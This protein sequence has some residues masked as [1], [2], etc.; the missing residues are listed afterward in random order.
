VDKIAK[1]LS[2]LKYVDGTPRYTTWQDKHNLPPASPNWW[3]AI[4]DAIEHCDMFV[5]NLSRASL[6]SGVCRAELDYAHKRNRPIVPVVLEDEF[7]LDAQS[8]KYDLPKET[9]AL[10]PD[11]LR[12]TQF[13]FYIETQFYSKFEE[14]VA[15]FERSWP[16]DIPA[17]RPLNP[18]SKAVHG[19]NHALYD[20]ACEYAGRLAFVD[21]EKHFDTLVR[22]NDSD[23]ADAAAWWLQVIRAYGELIE[24]DER[25]SAPFVFKKKW[26]TYITLFPSDFLEAPVFDPRSFASRGQTSA[27]VVVS[28]P[29]VVH[30]TSAPAKPTK[31]RSIDLLPG[32]F[33]WV[34]IPGGRGTMKTD[35]SGVT[36]TIPTQRYWIAKYPLTNAQYGLFIDADGYTQNRWWTADGIEARQQGIEWNWTGSAWEKKV[37]GKPW[38]EPRYWQ[39]S[40]WNGKE[41]PVV[42]V[43]WFE[44]VAYCQWLSDVTG[45][46]IM[47]PTEEQ[48]QYAAQGDEGR[49]YPWGKS[50]DASRCNNNVD[51]KGIGKTTPVRQYEGKGDSPF[52]VVD[53]AGNVWEW[54]LTDYENR[55]SDVNST[56]NKRVLRGGSWVSNDSG[57]FRCAFRNGVNPDFRN[58][59][60]GFRAALS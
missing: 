33:A 53:M 13:L 27:P 58:F 25:R 37:T 18:D 29:V 47:L 40:K 56:A 54:C 51:S 38:T 2:L 26:T 20:A 55:T 6:Q 34:E 1:D 24:L 41:Q 22:R 44:A 14:A 4:V 36:L 35:E 42:G 11:W 23:Y 49:D 46:K 28:P 5:L 7:F 8:G 57:G 30:A 21:A 17:P 39:D 50:W 59:Y 15:V 60:W 52:K 32:P 3:D 16:R 45:E 12:Q 31:P 48:W 43:S 19:S 10:V 9:W